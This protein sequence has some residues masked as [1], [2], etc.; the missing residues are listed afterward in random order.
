MHISHDSSPGVRSRDAQLG[1][2]R[3]ILPKHNTYV[4]KDFAGCRSNPDGVNKQTS[5]IRPA[6][7]SQ[8]HHQGPKFRPPLLKFGIGHESRATNGVA[9]I[10][11]IWTTDPIS[12]SRLL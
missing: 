12:L 3:T 7:L 1:T 11:S 8:L 4:F 10:H 2:K 6:G 9:A 5:H